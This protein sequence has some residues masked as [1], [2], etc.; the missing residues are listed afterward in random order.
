M[1]LHKYTD[2]IK[3]WLYNL[4]A[5]IAIAITPMSMHKALAATNC[6]QMLQKQQYIDAHNCFVAK[7]KEFDQQK[8][9][10][11]RLQRVQKGHYILKASN[12]AEKQASTETTS[13]KNSFWR[14]QAI[15][16]LDIYYKEDLCIRVH[17]C[18][19]ALGKIHE[20][21][22]L[23]GYGNLTIT[24]PPQLHSAKAQ[25]QGYRYND[26]RNKLTGQWNLSQLRPGAY[27]INIHVAQHR[28]QCHAK[29]IPHQNT[30]ISC[31]SSTEIAKLK[32]H[33]PNTGEVSQPNTGSSSKAV[34][35]TAWTLVVLGIVSSV[36]GGVLLGIGN[37]QIN[38]NDADIEQLRQLA[39][40]SQQAA[41][42]QMASEQRPPLDQNRQI[43]SSQITAAWIALPLGIASLT[44]GIVLLLLHRPAQHNN[45]NTPTL[46]PSSRTYLFY[47]E[48]P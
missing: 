10:L 3:K 17:R 29:I 9:A 14:E 39:Q 11:T 12:S 48:I 45:A 35:V 16:L 33:K 46:S 47:S 1:Q 13:E 15:K 22:K 4:G 7:A 18:R 32:L 38:Q 37:H 28:W 42:P 20:L 19:Q 31:P 21:R 23:I 2:L 6:E 24:L 30:Q 5:V 8:T 34:T 27:L 44:T 43:A 40:N 25:I 36:A 41:L 26:L